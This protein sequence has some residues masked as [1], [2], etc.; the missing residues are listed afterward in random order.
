MGD[1]KIQSF[2]VIFI[3]YFCDNRTLI[4]DNTRCKSLICENMELMASSLVSPLLPDPLLS[5]FF[6]LCIFFPSIH[7]LTHSLIHPF[8]FKTG[9]HVARSGF[10]LAM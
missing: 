4:C 1:A 10:A 2:S 6:P 3:Y 9:S 8:I 7:S 5:S